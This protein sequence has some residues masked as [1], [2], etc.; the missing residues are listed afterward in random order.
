MPA[1]T[2]RNKAKSAAPPTAKKPPGARAKTAPQAAVP[3]ASKGAPKNA[4]K[5]ALKSV[6]KA[7]KTAP[8]KS[9]K[10]S[11]QAGPKPNSFAP[12]PAASSISRFDLRTVPGALG[13]V[14]L[15]RLLLAL[16]VL[17][18]S[19][20][21][22]GTRIEENMALWPPG[23]PLG[24]WLGR[25]FVAPWIRWDG[26]QY[27]SIL[28]HGYKLD[29]GQTAF[30]PLYL[31]LSWPFM[32]AG[33]WPTAALL[34]VA[35][36]ASFALCLVFTRYIAKFHPGV[37]SNSAAWLLMGGLCGFILFAPYNESLFMALA[38]GSIWAMREERF[39]LAGLL[40]GLATLTRQQGIALLLPLIW[41][42]ATARRFTWHIL[43]TPLL[44]CA[45]YGAFV[46]YRIFVLHDADFSKAH[47]PLQV[48]RMIL[49]SPAAQNIVPGQHLAWPWQTIEA[50]WRLMPVTKGQPLIIDL[51][52]GG[53][54][55]IASLCGWKNLHP[56]ERMYSF[57][58]AML[59]LCYYNGKDHPLL[60]LPRHVMLAFP[61]YIT[62]ARS[63]QHPMARYYFAIAFAIN[64]ILAATFFRRVWVP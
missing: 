5:S 23:Q 2:N 6:P 15:M 50:Q 29:E 34:I 64:F 42:I 36:L 16:W 44:V 56:T 27:T 47:T 52:L 63:A 54:M 9:S 41:Q 8:G 19:V 60:S 22:P 25:V 48:L 57:T 14:L 28:R 32:K 38:I 30:H 24:S 59:P 40:G 21:Y 10:T 17:P 4:P 3:P 20:R 1:P 43:L 12:P 39:W 51:L 58:I 33:L 61:L 35:T 11:P 18:F 46:V 31:L 62:L 49:V 45:G 53:A 13:A 37:S 26:I 55:V 7:A